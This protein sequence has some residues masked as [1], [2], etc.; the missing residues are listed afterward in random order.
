MAAVR[1][2]RAADLFA[3]PN[4]SCMPMLAAWSRSTC[5]LGGAVMLALVNGVVA[6]I[7]EALRRVPEDL[8]VAVL[9]DG[10]EQALLCWGR[11]QPVR[12][13]AE[14][15]QFAVGSAEP[16]AVGWPRQLTGGAL[17]QLDYEFPVGAWAG[18]PASTSVRGHALPV[19]HRLEWKGSCWHG[20]AA[21]EAAFDQWPARSVSAMPVDAGIA[22]GMN[23][24]QHAER[25]ARIKRWISAGD[26]YQANLTLPFTTALTREHAPAVFTRLLESAPG[27]HSALFRLRDRVV[28]SHSPECMVRSDGRWCWS[29]PIKGTRPRYPGSEASTRA[30]LLAAAKDNAELAMIVDLVRNDLGRIARPGGVRVVDPAVVMDLPYVHHLVARVRCELADGITATDIIQ[31]VYPAGSIT[32]APKIRAMQILR[33][34]ELA[35]RGAYCGGI[36]WIGGGGACVLSVAIRTLVFTQQGGRFDAGGGIVADSEAGEEWAEVMAKASAMRRALGETA[37]AR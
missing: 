4:G 22:P 11:A 30:E 32:G 36:G 35:E 26:I 9:T 13:L 18:N 16:A 24:Q 28:V 10:G 7:E 14:L 3:G 19:E 25:V 29:E 37:D 17:V 15:N 31:A 6:A 23:E 12:E 33:E 27:V 5:T 21:S 34:L 8:D 1:I 2:M 20:S